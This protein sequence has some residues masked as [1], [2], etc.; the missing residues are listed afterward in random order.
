MSSSNPRVSIG[1]PVYNGANYIR[2][3]VRSILEQD[4]PDFE[5]IISDN[6]STDETEAICR[7]LVAEDPRVRY[8]RNEKN[9]GAARNYNIVFE[10]ARGEYFKWQAHDDECDPAMIRECVAALDQ[11]P[12]RVAM[13]YPL[14]VL[15]NE[16]GEVLRG[17]LDRIESRDSRPYYRLSRLFWEL[18]MCD[19]VFGLI[20]TSYLKQTQLIGAYFGADYVLLGELAMLG[21]IWEIDRPLFRLRAHPKRSM[22]ANANARTRA[23]WYDPKAGVKLF[24]LPSWERM[25]WE[26]VKS[27]WS[28]PALSLVERV[29]CVVAVLA[30]HY[31]RTFRNWGGRIKERVKNSLG[32]ASDRSVA[33][34]S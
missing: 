12:A 31:W 4:Y 8:H 23:S 1:L 25:M 3:A 30:T 33:E 34:R 20:R 18:N 16:H 28:F 6:A 5:L 29:K 9:L 13:V 17:P 14:A 15:I 32:P 24:V 27:A 2:A 26:M 19:P 22:K 21:E 7:E 11:A 10:L